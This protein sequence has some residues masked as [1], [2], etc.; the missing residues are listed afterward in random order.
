MQ[1]YAQAEAE[2]AKGE[3]KEPVLVSAGP[4]STLRQAYPNFFLDIAQFI[5]LVTSITEMGK[6]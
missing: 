6:E 4:L 3:K 5:S 1:D 2:A